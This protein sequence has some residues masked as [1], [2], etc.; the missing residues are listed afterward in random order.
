MRDRAVVLPAIIGP[1]AVGKTDFSLLLAEELGGE[2]ISVDSRQIYRY[3]DVG[4]DKV[5]PDV[6]RKIIHHCIDV[7]DPDQVFSVADF[8]KCASD[9]VER[10]L[11]RQRVPILAGG[12]PFYFKALEGG[13]LSDLPS[14]MNVRR[15]IELE[16][17]E[18]GRGA[19]YEELKSLDPDSAARINPND[20]HRI[21]RALEI[22]KA[23]GKPPTWWYR[24]NPPSSGG[25]RMIYI[26]LN[27]PRDELYRRIEE[28]VK[29]QFQSGYPE[30]VLWLL[31]NGFDERLPSMQGFGYRE[32]VAWAKGEMTFE[33]AMALDVR[34][35]KAFARR[36]MTW[37]KR[38]PV[39]R[40]YDL[41]LVS[42]ETLLQ[43]VRGEVLRR[44]EDGL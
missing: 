39:Y 1:T 35:T 28:R 44:M 18:R 16:M 8:V 15:A 23:S 24:N 34:C 14:D 3:L 26:G 17:Q 29:K 2:I 20:S 7:A 10:I 38:F 21:V 11:K 12:T 30:E 13:V 41:S 40:W 32:L 36:Q 22:Y 33:E 31:S 19:M 42:P 6:R 43:E 27:R 5:S 37:F 9:A 4:T 25:F